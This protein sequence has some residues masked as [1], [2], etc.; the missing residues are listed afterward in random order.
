[1][2]NVPP[3]LLFP[4][5]K[6]DADVLIVGGGLVGAALALALKD[7]SLSVLLLD[8]RAPHF[9]W[10]AES[11][12]SRVY[13]ISGAS[14]RLLEQVGA[15]PGMP[16]ERLQ[17]VQT[18]RILGDSGS[19]LRFDALE[20]GLTE[21]ATIL[22]SRELQKALWQAVQAC[23]NVRI[24]APA[25]PAHLAVDVEAATLVLA[26]GRSVCARLVVGADGAQSWIRSQLG[27]APQVHDYHQFGVV[28]NFITEK[29]HLGTAWQWF[30]EDGVLAWLPLAGQRMSMVWS[31]PQALRDEL[32]ALD[33]AQLA[34]RVAQAGGNRLGHLETI[35]PA[36]AF[37]LR[38]NRLSTIVSPRVA[39]IGDAAHTVHPLAGQGVNLG[40]GDVAELAGILSAEAVQRCGDLSVLRRYARARRE[41]VMMMQGVCHGLQQLFNNTNPVLKTLRNMGLGVTNQSEW[42][43]RQLIRQAAGF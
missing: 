1:M 42:L 36:A 8:A 24:L 40:F 17:S 23:P 28:A 35:T 13:A 9:D 6:L 3:L 7:T 38:L 18:M 20:A 43:K 19:A 11:W 39:L 14:R 5:K 12:D 41:P 26:D 4:M 31:C 25:E 30:R 33:G 2:F 15:W 29:P 21:L 27:M 37:P 10:P 22:E 16:A 32:L 34:Q